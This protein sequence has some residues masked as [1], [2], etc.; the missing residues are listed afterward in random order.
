MLKHFFARYFWFV[1]LLLFVVCLLET[2]RI[3]SRINNLTFQARTTSLKNKFSYPNAPIMPALACAVFLMIFAKESNAW[4]LAYGVCPACEIGV[5]DQASC[6]VFEKRKCDSPPSPPPPPPTP[7]PHPLGLGDLNFDY[8][9]GPCCP[10]ELEPGK[11]AGVAVGVLVPV[12]LVIF[13]MWRCR[14]CCFKRM[15]D[16]RQSTQAQV[17]V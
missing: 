5:R 7:P 3:F 4:S 16:L 9:C 6:R 12:L 15:E 13:C 10:C 2:N 1:V 8:N 14:C 17:Q 11:V